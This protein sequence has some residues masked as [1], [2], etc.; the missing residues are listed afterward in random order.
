M[1][2][3]TT[4]SKRAMQQLQVD[5][6]TKLQELDHTLLAERITRQLTIFFHTIGT[7]FGALHKGSVVFGDASLNSVRS[8]NVDQVVMQHDD[9]RKTGG[10]MF[11]FDEG[12]TRWNTPC[13]RRYEI[14][15]TS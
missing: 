13:T 11:I 12:C 10:G 5:Q 9:V 7:V 15:P 3:T 14:M 6:I 1:E 8:T 4:P 2:A